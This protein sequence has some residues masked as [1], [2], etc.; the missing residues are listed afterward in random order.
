[1]RAH[2]I[3]ELAELDFSYLEI[4]SP[5]EFLYNADSTYAPILIQD[6]GSYDPLTIFN[7]LQ[8]DSSI[9]LASY[10][11]F[12]D[13]MVLYTNIDNSMSSAYL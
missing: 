10:L 3:Y 8:N 13:D 12:F 1:M 9:C 2:P 7:I 5:C 6:K 4:D 11:S